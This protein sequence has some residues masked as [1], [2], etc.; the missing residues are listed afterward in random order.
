MS[1]KIILTGMRTTGR[2]HLG[3]YVGALQQWLELQDEYTCYFLLADVQALT[4]H[5]DRVAEI[6]DSVL[7]VAMDWISSGIDPVRS[8]FVL[9]S[10]VRQYPELTAYLMM[11]ENLN[12]LLKNPTI[13]QEALE[14]GARGAGMKPEQLAAM[15]E[16]ER[17][18]MFQEG[19]P[20]MNAGFLTYPISQAADILLLTPDPADG[21]SHLLVPVGEDQ[22]PHIEACRD[23]ARRFNRVYGDHGPT[24][25]VP[26]A[27]VGIVGRLPD[28]SA[29]GGKM[30]KSAGNAIFLS[31]SPAKVV[32]KVRQGT[33]DPNKVRRNDPGNPEVCPIFKYHGVFSDPEATA[34]VEAGCRS[35]QL[36]C[37]DCKLRLAGSINCLLEPMRQRRAELEEQPQLVAEAI[38][39]GTARAIEHG[40]RTMESVRRAMHLDYPTVF[41]ASS[42]GQ[43]AATD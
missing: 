10:A 37:V 32:E 18:R 22:V 9:Q 23:T 35:G 34:E 5:F 2:L 38:A 25:V 7:Q 33:T 26:Q 11:L 40:E 15:S 16:E 8:S 24:F 19:L 6:E 21:H 1:S 43:A 12:S 27:K 4:T 29:T 41:R 30:G 17:E 14:I 13:K 20:G 39:S 42:E 31:D 3:H 36:G 28:L